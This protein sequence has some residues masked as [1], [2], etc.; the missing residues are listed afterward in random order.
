MTSN[1]KQ[2]FMNCLIC[3]ILH[4]H[5]TLGPNLNYQTQDH[6]THRLAI[7]KKVMGKLFVHI[8]LP[9]C[10][11]FLICQMKVHGVPSS[12]EVGRIRGIHPWDVFGA[13]PGTK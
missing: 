11:S 5:W 12:W 13:T 1:L 10:L 7:P 9:P 4:Q 3:V 2:A 8:A 6:N